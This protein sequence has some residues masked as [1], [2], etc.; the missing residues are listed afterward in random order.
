LTR[1]A[2]FWQDGSN[3]KKTGK[4]FTQIQASRL[5][6]RLQA[7]PKLPRSKKIESLEFEALMN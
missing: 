3:A 4:A 5:V 7:S 6:N 1:F 2:L